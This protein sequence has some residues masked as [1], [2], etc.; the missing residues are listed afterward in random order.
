VDAAGRSRVEFIEGPSGEWVQANL[1]SKG[2]RHVSVV[3]SILSIDEHD[4][5]GVERM[6]QRREPRF[7]ATP[8]ATPSSAPSS[9]AAYI[10]A[11]L[12]RPA[13]K[14][15][16]TPVRAARGWLLQAGFF[17]VVAWLVRPQYGASPTTE[18]KLAVAVAVLMV[19]W[20]AMAVAPLWLEGRT[21]RA[22]AW[23]D[24]PKVLRLTALASLHP[25]IRSRPALRWSFGTQRAAALAGSGRLDE[26][27][28]LVERVGRDN[29][30]TQSLVTGQK[31]NL[32]VAMHR[33]DEAIALRRQ[34]VQDPARRRSKVDLA[35]ALLQHR[36]DVAAA[37]AELAD[38]TERPLSL[39][40]AAFRSFA[41]GLLDLEEG[42]F[43]EAVASITRARRA[44]E[45][46][47]AAVSQEGLML[48]TAPPL[49]V[50]L[51]R[52]GQR[53]QA[54]AMLPRVTQYLQATGQP[55]W[56]ERCREAIAA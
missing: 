4:L 44:F 9:I 50:A 25:F 35:I 43:S 13:P 47:A 21:R 8:E 36:R 10:D 53:E 17:A 7:D 28:E 1:Q 26:A 45:R 52:S 40:E 39:L 37:R 38:L 5:K 2:A 22:R 41:Y 11:T 49:C 19:P 18:F 15:L 54:A 42:R 3:E 20:G 30:M 51:A 56:L 23:N 32:Y 27:L 14:P 31:A 33:Y 29:G 12:E 24:W 6:L 46:A 16:T 48:W 34:S 55:E